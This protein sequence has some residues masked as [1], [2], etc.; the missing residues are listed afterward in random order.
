MILCFAA[1]TEQGEYSV[2]QR[3]I[4][5]TH[6]LQIRAAGVFRRNLHGDF[7]NCLFIEYFN[8][9]FGSPDGTSPRFG[10]NSQCESERKNVKWKIREFALQEGAQRLLRQITTFGHATMPWRNPNPH[11]LFER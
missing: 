11:R 2:E 5:P 9:H 8:N 1:Y 6:L 4:V 7:E 3:P 10:S